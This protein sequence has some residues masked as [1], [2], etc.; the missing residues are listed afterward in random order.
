MSRT[1]IVMVNILAKNIDRV[2]LE[3]FY[4]MLA[5]RGFGPK[6]IQMIKQV[7]RGG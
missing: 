4:E 2:N 3:F 5:C 1:T 6:I 7:T